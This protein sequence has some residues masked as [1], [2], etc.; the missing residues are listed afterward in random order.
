MVN[1]L[2]QYGNLKRRRDFATIE[3]NVLIKRT[4]YIRVVQVFNFVVLKSIL[5]N[6]LTKCCVSILIA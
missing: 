6:D 5:R 2:I 4:I 1:A 3:S